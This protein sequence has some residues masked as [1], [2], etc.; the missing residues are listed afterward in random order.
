[1]VLVNNP[2]AEEYIN[3]KLFI[4]EGTTIIT[5]KDYEDWTNLVQIS[6]PRSVNVIEPGAF[7]NSLQISKL[8]CDPKFFNIFSDNCII[9]I[10]I[11][12]FITELSKGQFDNLY[13]LKNLILPD[14]IKINDP[15]IFDSC[16]NLTSIHTSSSVFD[17]LSE[18]TR[19]RC[20]EKVNKKEYVDPI[21]SHQ[22]SEII[23]LNNYESS[24]GLPEYSM[25]YD[26]DFFEKNNLE[27]IMPKSSNEPLKR[28]K[29]TTIDDLVKFDKE[30]QKYSRY[31]LDIQMNIIQSKTPKTYQPKNTSLEEIALICGIVCNEIKRYFLITLRPVQILTILRITDNVLNNR[32]SHGSIGEVKT[33][34]GKT[35]I[36]TVATIILV[37]FKC[38]VD[39]V[40]SNLELVRRDQK[41]QEKYFKHFMIQTGI[42]YNKYSDYEYI[43]N[44]KDI[45]YTFSNED[46]QYGT[47]NMNVL[48]CPVVYS[49]H[50]NFEYLYLHSIFNMN[51]RN[52]KYDVVL[53]DEVDNMFID[54][55]TS[56]LR[57]CKPVNFAFSNDI[58][59]IVFYLQSLDTNEII[60]ILNYY[61]P[62]I[63]IFEVESI[64]MLKEAAKKAMKFKN[65]VD[66]IIQDRKVIVID[67]NTGFKK[68]KC[69]YGKFV[70]EMIEI[71]EHLEINECSIDSCQITQNG[72][73]NLYRKIIGVTETIGS[74]DDENILKKGYNV[75]LFRVPR[76]FESQKKVFVKNRPT[77]DADLYREVFHEILEEKSK[78]RPVLVIWDSIYNA[79][80]FISAYP[81]LITQQIK[82]IDPYQDRKSI[83][84]AGK[85]GT[86]TIATSAAGRGV[87]IILSNESLE[88]GGLHVIIPKLLKN[89]RSLEQAEGRAGRQGQPGSV[90]FYTSENDKFDKLH[91]FK[92][93]DEYLVK[94]EHMFS[95]YLRKHFP[96]MLLAERKWH[97][98]NIVYPFNA[99]PSIILKILARKIAFVL[100]GNPFNEV[101]DKV[102]DLSFDMVQIAWSVFFTG[103]NYNIEDCEDWDLVNNLY[104]DF[105]KELSYWFPPEKCSTADKAVWHI[106]GQLLKEKDWE[107][108]IIKG[109]KV[110]SFGFCIIFPIAAPVIILVTGVVLSGGQEIYHQ[111]QNG[112]KINW[113]Q[114]LIRCCGSF[115]RNA[116]FLT[117]HYDFQ[118]IN[119]VIY[120]F[121]TS[122]YNMA[123]NKTLEMDDDDIYIEDESDNNIQLSKNINGMS[124][125]TNKWLYYNIRNKR[126]PRHLIK[127]KPKIYPTVLNIDFIRMSMKLANDSYI[128]KF[129]FGKTIF[130][131]EENDFFKPVFYCIEDS[132]QN[133][134]IVTRGSNS[135][136]DYS[137][138]FVCYEVN[139]TI[140]GKVTYFHKGFYEASIYILSKISGFLKKNYKTIYFI[141]HSYAAAVSSILTLLTKSN[142]E[143]SN[144]DIYGIAFAPPPAM[145]P[146]PANISDCIYSFINKNDIVPSLC[147]A[148]LANMVDENHCTTK[149]IVGKCLQKLKYF[150]IDWVNK[151][152][153]AIEENL[154]LIISSIKLINVRN[155]QGK[156]YRIGLGKKICLNDCRI[157]E[158]QLPTKIVTELTS[159]ADHLMDD[160]IKSFKVI[161]F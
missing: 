12:D 8:I 15:D 140:N 126:K 3:N 112:E 68:L 39:I 86:I 55:F 153:C 97:F 7:K 124:Q 116:I 22:S 38:K 4:E 88:A 10:T 13:F 148:N 139:Q 118:F 44:V 160:Y 109:I 156:I 119:M 32:N 106:R 100:K 18:I 63:G 159:A 43:E 61:F 45:I 70:H 161:E 60:K 101:N 21:L 147:L 82:G 125:N 76:H 71:K 56:P 2:A 80:Q 23:Y 9:E 132:D 50:S 158:S 122:L 30:N 58:F 89:Q 92:K 90:T 123:A 51:P 142:T 20:M 77:R 94:V 134:F 73:F 145:S 157:I 14:N 72:Y 24:I 137:T 40:S 49:T 130:A 114:V 17:S 96:W 146:I 138:D 102:Q 107:N 104:E 117:F 143:L 19:K 110:S 27:C 152:V 75:E 28:Q 11:P 53:V 95:N 74:S 36:I 31:I 91:E 133:L 34:E 62:E 29:E 16:Q 113:V 131:S 83:K 78:G 150:K 144:K 67:K 65:K 85:E 93:S 121:E 66:Y 64:N 69:R 129:T 99:A 98:I 87:D 79:D 6:I 127:L 108:I 1:M 35:I 5:Q 54:E 81:N 128:G 111:L 115:I 120:Y 47:F 136:Y 37:K 26:D 48:D 154:D 135:G 151:M 103:L 52:R 41:E 155:V 25:S 141:G 46:N 57:I 33:G 59:Q 105:I 84:E 149:L 42:L